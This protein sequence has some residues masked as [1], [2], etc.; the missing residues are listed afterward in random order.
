MTGR[1]NRILF[2]PNQ[3]NLVQVYTN[4]PPGIDS[5]ATAYLVLVVRLFRPNPS[6]IASSRNNF[7]NDIY[8]LVRWWG[9]PTEAKCAIFYPRLSHKVGHK[10]ITC[11]KARYRITVP[12]DK[13][14]AY[15]RDMRELRLD[16]IDVHHQRIIGRG[17]LDR[18]DR[19]TTITPIDTI[20]PVI[21]EVGEKLGDLNV[22]IMIEPV[23]NSNPK[24]VFS[25]FIWKTDRDR[26]NQNINIEDDHDVNK[27]K[28]MM[29]DKNSMNSCKQEHEV[30]LSSSDTHIGIDEQVNLIQS[31]Q[32][33]NIGEHAVDLDIGS[34]DQN[35]YNDSNKYKLFTTCY[36]QREEITITYY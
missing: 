20:L 32:N 11:T 16:V 28:T 7:L 6:H 4:L 23:L 21:N 18:I 33:N 24:P 14:S 27:Q 8:V 26:L 1:L 31:Q 29:N 9:E 12:L 3:R 34:L 2:Q 10:Q 15:L 5:K 25:R 36:N 30:S 13:F 22:S 19:L 35:H 17:R